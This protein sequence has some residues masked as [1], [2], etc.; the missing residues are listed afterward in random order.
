MTT[1]KNDQALPISAVERDTGLGKDTLRVWERRYGFP[2]PLR[3]DKGERL[4]PPDQVERLHQIRRLM[5]QGLR[6][7]KLLAASDTELAALLSSASPNTETLN[8]PLA[9]LQH[10]DLPALN[11][12][13]YQALAS[14]GL[15]DFVISQL[16][17]LNVQVGEAWA[18]GQ[19]SVPQEHLYTE[20]VQTLLRARLHQLPQSDPLPRILL[21]TLPEELHTLGLLMTQTL[22]A[23]AGANCTS[24]G[25]QTPVADLAATLARRDYDVLVL[26]FS[27]AFSRRNAIASLQSLSAGLPEDVEIWAGGRLLA[28]RPVAIAGVR[29]L[30]KLED[31]LTVLAQWRVGHAAQTPPY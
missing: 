16:A 26:G 23:S 17:P 4:Y 7:G 14:H 11:A 8:P 10:N 27:G 24:L 2:R 18:R 20:A 29:Y 28:E 22:L 19:L 21:T 12:W 25:A 1:Q 15:A 6:P 9:A 31:C 13:L 5:D 3:D 30:E